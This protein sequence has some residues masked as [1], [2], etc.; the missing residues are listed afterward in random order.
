M[1]E[2]TVVRCHVE[3]FTIMWKC[4]QNAAGITQKIRKYAG[5]RAWK[6]NEKLH[7]F[8]HRLIYKL[9]HRNDFFHSSD[10]WKSYV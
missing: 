6:M 4:G 7:Y 8:I 3:F 2:K 5:Q 1:E 10:F 9:Q